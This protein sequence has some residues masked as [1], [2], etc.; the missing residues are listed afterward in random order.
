MSLHSVSK[1]GAFNTCQQ[2]ATHWHICI[3]LKL[4]VK[5]VTIPEHNATANKPQ[6]DPPTW[7]CTGLSSNSAWGVCSTFASCLGKADECA[8]YKDDTVI[9]FHYS[10]R[11][12]V[13][14]LRHISNGS[15]K[16]SLLK[17]NF[18]HLNGTYKHLLGLQHKMGMGDVW[19]WSGHSTLGLHVWG[20]TG[21]SAECPGDTV[22]GRTG[23]T[24][25]RLT[26]VVSPLFCFPGPANVCIVLL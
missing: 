23:S 19:H 17:Q 22:H 3:C 20:T 8:E 9:Y 24:P 7:T 21:S 5:E 15:V 14:T 26:P 4:Q 11:S 13:R 18:G 25:I 1:K 6:S 2:M 10:R 16:Y 12:T